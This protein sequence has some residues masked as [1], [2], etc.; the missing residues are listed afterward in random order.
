MCDLSLK[1]KFQI[2][3]LNVWRVNDLIEMFLKEAVTAQIV[4]F[5]ILE[6]E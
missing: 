5:P 6:D 1:Y 4:G 2:D 3:A